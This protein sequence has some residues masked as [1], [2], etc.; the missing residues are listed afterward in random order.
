MMCLLFSKFCV[1]SFS[2]LT[3]LYLPS[4]RLICLVL[5][6]STEVLENYNKSPFLASENNFSDSAGGD[7]TG[8]Y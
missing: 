2:F 7:H 5:D 3:S 4:L 6:F 1:S 8:D